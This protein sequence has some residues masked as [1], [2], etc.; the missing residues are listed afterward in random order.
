M[1]SFG[2]ICIMVSL[3]FCSWFDQNFLA[4]T[5]MSSHHLNLSLL[6]F[7]KCFLI[8]TLF[9]FHVLIDI[10]FIKENV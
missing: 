8:F 4:K 10:A 2:E 9:Q 6:V 5:V 1:M 7:L 3:P